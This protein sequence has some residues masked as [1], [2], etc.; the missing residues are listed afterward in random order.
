[1]THTPHRLE[2][3][4]A[5][6]GYGEKIVIHDLS[7]QVPHGA[8]VA[9]V[10][11]NG[12][13][14]STLFKALVGILPLK[15]GRIL[16]HGETLGT[17]KDCVAYVPQREDVDWRFPVT[18]SDVVMMGRFGQIGWWSQPSK[19]DRQIVRKSIEQMGIADLAELSIGQ[20]SGGQQQRAFLARALAQEP[21]ILLM[22]EP[23]TGIDATTQEVTFGLLDHLRKQQVTTII[24]THDLNLAASRFDLVLLINHRLIA[25]GAPSQVFTKENLA[26]AF[27]NSLLVM[28]NGMMLVDECCPPKKTRTKVK[29][30]KKKKKKEKKKKKKPP[31]RG[32]GGGG[33][34]GPKKK[35]GGGGQSKIKIQK[36]KM[37]WFL[38][39]LAYQ[40][41][42]R[43][44]FASVIVGV[45]CAVMGTYVVLRGMAFLGDAMAHAI[46][47]GVAIAYLLQGNLLVGAGVAAVIV[48][49]SIGL[50]SRE[51]TVKE[52]TAIG[53]LFAAALSLGVALISS[54]QTYAV[55]LSHILFGNVLGVSSSDLWMIVGLSF[56]I[57]LTV[58]LFFK[59]FLVISFDPVL[60][61]TLRLPAE[62]L[63]NLMLVLLALTVVVSLQTVGVSLAAAMLVTPAATAYLLTRRLLPMMLVSALIGAL[64]SVIGLYLSYYLNIV[65]GSTI[66]L[67][68][69]AFFLITFLWKRTR[70]S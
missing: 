37:N 41:M 13:G 53:I 43:G 31:P 46:L 52:D 45:L 58:S 66:V 63:R 55:D 61:A 51:G 68:A 48:A 12:A 59:Q 17:H 42:Q 60:A 44:L 25:F 35:R 67:T 54:M 62:L 19:T 56:V 5:S 20:L 15:S 49:L 39:P 33:G 27:G 40:F 36:S 3:E 34:G 24:S 16:I 70:S 28:D 65:S 23:F 32:G 7:F 29:K 2:I 4:N 50:F 64:S 10:G 21:H 69:T 9:V 30:K 26:S 18:V 57:L 22:D 47:P 6:I 38:E 1:M 8:R 11:P 14:K